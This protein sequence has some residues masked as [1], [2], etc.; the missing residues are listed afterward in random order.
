MSVSGELL[1]ANDATWGA[2][3][4][5]GS[6]LT[7]E[8]T[9]GNVKNLAVNADMSAANTPVDVNTQANLQVG[10]AGHKATTGQHRIYGMLEILTGAVTGCVPGQTTIFSGATLKVD[11][12]ISV[13]QYNNTGDLFGINDT[14]S[15]HDTLQFNSGAK[16]MLG[17]GAVWARDI[18]VGSAL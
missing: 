7:V 13:P 4:S 9:S 1:L 6:T 17:N 5:G 12:N 14:G 11:N 10:G 18:T 3:P 15:P 8:G 16:L 2:A